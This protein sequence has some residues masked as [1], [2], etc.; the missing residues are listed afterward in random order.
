MNIIMRSHVSGSENYGRRTTKT[1]AVSTTV[2]CISKVLV[3]MGG[4]TTVP[5]E[6]LKNIRC[7]HAF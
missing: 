6:N 7:I 1:V 5:S 4:A 2:V 3:T